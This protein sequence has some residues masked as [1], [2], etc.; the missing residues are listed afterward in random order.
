MRFLTDPSFAV[1]LNGQ[2]VTFEDIDNPNISKQT[3][4]IGSGRAVELITIDTQ[5]TDRTTKQH[6]V[7]WHIGGRLV[8]SCTWKGVGADDLIDGRKIAAK[9]FTF[10]VKADHLAPAIKPDWSGFDKDN[11]Q[12]QE[13]A[14]VV[15]ETVRTYLLSASEE[16]RRETLAKARERNSETLKTLGPLEREKWTKFVTKAQENCPSVKESDIIKLSEVVANLEQSQSGY[17]LLHKLSEYG[18][19]QLDELHQ[20]LADWTLDMAKAVLDE[21]AR[22][23]KL[24]DEL[25]ARIHDKKTQEVQDLQPLFEKGLWIF[26]P[27]FETIEYTANEGMTR[28]VQ[29]LF[30]RPDLS[31]TRNRPDFAILPDGTCG[32]YSYPRYDDQGG[33]IGTARLVVIELKK[34]GVTISE[35]QK[36]Q[37][38]K[39]VKELYE[40]GL[41]QAKQTDVR[42]FVLGS[43]VDNLESSPRTEMD[44]TVCIQPM[45]FN[46]VL[47]RARSRLL[48]LTDRVKDAPFLKNH[49]K[50]IDDFLSVTNTDQTLF[51]AA[52]V[53]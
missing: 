3:I 46:T 27:E 14:K 15:Y 49:R 31:G 39:Y 21:I 33:E 51:D 34:P 37:C 28:V 24:V 42:C 4:D 32:L 11:E 40:K 30:K 44:N 18:P 2:A 45:L 9:R 6:G 16:D 1:S 12:F 8:G 43:L 10:I 53:A 52:A 41:L 5:V 22:R 35:D 29:D 7:A 20:L 25:N 50:E 13:A 23:L 47:Q 48:K 19:N 26:G 36:A 17:A 38:W